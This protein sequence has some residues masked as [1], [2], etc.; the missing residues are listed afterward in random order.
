[1]LRALYPT[2]AAICLA[3]LPASPALLAAE[4]T[5]ATDKQPLPPVER[6]PLEERSQEDAAGLERQLP[7][8]EQ[9]QLRAGEESF[10]ALWQPANVSDPSGLLIL[11]PGEGES[12]DWPQAI[13]PLRHSLPDSG[14]NR[15]VNGDVY[16]N[17]HTPDFVGR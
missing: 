1:M 7:R 14:W 4:A 3:L 6:A 16:R 12:A 11:L 10:L 17:P 5:T 9:Q 2:L 8:R 15:I 13:G